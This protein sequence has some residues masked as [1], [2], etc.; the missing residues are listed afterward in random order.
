M[1]FKRKIEKR[2]EK[3]RTGWQQQT[4]TIDIKLGSTRQINPEIG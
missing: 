2:V 4:I 3:K 1:N